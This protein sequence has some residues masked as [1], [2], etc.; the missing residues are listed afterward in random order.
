[1]R[2]T[3]VNLNLVAAAAGAVAAVLAVLAPALIE[4]AEHLPLWLGVPLVLAVMGLLTVAAFAAGIALS[5][6]NL[7]Q[8]RRR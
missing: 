4:G 5:E 8:P 1:M 2:V 3:N 6:R 7:R